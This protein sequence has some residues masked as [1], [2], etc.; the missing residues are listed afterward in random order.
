[1]ALLECF[2]EAWWKLNTI[3]MVFGIPVEKKTW[4]FGKDLFI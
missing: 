2:P 3:K 1:M 4:G